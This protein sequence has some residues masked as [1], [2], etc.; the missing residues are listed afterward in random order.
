MAG[1]VID[2]REDQRDRETDHN[3]DDHESL[4][5]VWYFKWRKHLRHY[6]NK[7]PSYDC[8][9]D[10]DAIN[11]SSLQLGKEFFE[12]HTGH[13][14]GAADFARL[15]FINTRAMHLHANLGPI[16]QPT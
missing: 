8:V 3:G 9:R 12:V 1:E 6:L 14:H 7:Q 2:P 4:R 10:G 13:L 5:P 11:P 15:A 16:R